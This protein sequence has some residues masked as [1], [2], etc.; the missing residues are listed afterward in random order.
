MKMVSV[1]F[2]C[3]HRWVTCIP[4]GQDSPRCRT[5]GCP[6][7]R[8]Q[9]EVDVTDATMAWEACPRCHKPK[10]AGSKH[11]A[12]CIREMVLIKDATTVKNL[13]SDLGFRVTEGSGPH[14]APPRGDT[15]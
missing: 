2:D 11:C 4:K 7:I 6:E 12:R 13:L 5:C 8:A 1:T 10:G 15:E 9:Y 14:D 3:G